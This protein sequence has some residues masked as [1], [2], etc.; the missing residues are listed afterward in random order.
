[1]ELLDLTLHNPDE[2]SGKS[3]VFNGRRYVIGEKLGVGAEKIVHAAVN[4]MSGLSLFVIKILRQPRPV[5]KVPEIL[6]KLRASPQKN[7]EFAR[8][9]PPVIEFE[10]PGGL[11]ELQANMD[12]R[13]NPGTA[14][15]AACDEGMRLLSDETGGAGAVAA[16]RRALQ[17]NPMH[18]EAMMGLAQALLNGDD[19]FRALDWVERA[20][21]IEP[22][23]L[24]YWRALMTVG[25]STGQIGLALN[26]YRQA[27]ACFPTIHDLDDLGA[28]LFIDAGDPEGARNCIS[29]ALLTKEQVDERKREIE[30]AI[31]ARSQAR[32]LLPL[33]REKA[34]QKDWE[35]ASRILL[36]AQA[37]YNR[38]PELCM[39][40]AFCSYRAGDP[41]VA[42]ALMLHA[43]SVVSTELRPTCS[44]NAAF[45]L[46]KNGD[47]PM[48]L[49]L[50]NSLAH[51]LAS[52]HHGK[53]PDLE[54]DLPGIGC[55]IEGRSLAEE[56]I[57][58]A[59]TV[60]GQAIGEARRTMA[61]PDAV[62][63]LVEAYSHAAQHSRAR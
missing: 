3:V 43:K 15:D 19:R 50:L 52:A 37:T 34:E 5:G 20:V 25:R 16:F 53:I 47:L 17:A 14:A 24:S 49:Q 27:A 46:I 18:T 58:T 4:E 44:A 28:E 30:D 63:A 21:G 62:E 55:W 29:T 8:I 23:Q 26:A 60:L 32:A 57:S 22:N 12:R 54:L 56:R 1:M 10:V 41:R 40:T 33:A 9:I 39:N 42:I 2:Y 48:A 31:A 11:V 7:F 59:A 13:R 38:D 35:A 61:V 51:D 36:Q 45:A 6:A